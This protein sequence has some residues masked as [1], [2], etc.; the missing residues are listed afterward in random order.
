MVSKIILLMCAV[1][2]L[3]ACAATER[4]VDAGFIEF[5][6]QTSPSNPNA[7]YGRL[8]RSSVDSKYHI[9]NSAGV[10]VS[11]LDTSSSI[12]V[13]SATGVL[14]LANG[15]T[16]K[17]LTASN[18]G[19][20]YSDADSLEL[21]AVGSTG[22]VFQSNGAGAPTWSTPTY[23]SASGSAGKILRADGTNNLY[24][25]ATFPDTVTAN[26]VLYGSAS[27]IWSV[28]AT[29]NTSSF[30]TDS[31]GNI[32]WLSG[33]TANRLLRTNGTAISFSQADLTTDVTGALP[34][35]NGGSGQTTANAALN[36]FLPSQTGNGTKFLQTDGTNTSW[37]TASGG[38]STVYQATFK[39]SSGNVSLSSPNSPGSFGNFSGA[40]GATTTIVNTNMGT[41]STASG[42]PGF[43]F[44]PPV[45]GEYEI[46]V[47]FPIKLSNSA[48]ASE[49]V[50]FD[51]TT[52]IAF[53][54]YGSSGKSANEQTP[55]SI[56]GVYDATTTSATTISIKGN[57]STGSLSIGNFSGWG[58]AGMWSVK[59]IN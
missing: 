29:A 50:L 24:S 27:N 18:G 20:C 51:G 58:A 10:D 2:P 59:K 38:S 5:K 31:S 37:Q 57:V 9:L 54:E 53:L 52:N 46:T 32:S 30:V 49:I 7:G 35:A 16:N 44:T 34:I 42:V 55:V 14:A 19:V 43:Q 3:M 23:P 21:S 6:N 40:W 28:L 4:K 13:S 36:A 22:Q 47:N 26:G 1:F 33:S 41:I 45:T 8:Y 12:D 48:E 39:H 17:N 11:L 56:T 25:T 15:G